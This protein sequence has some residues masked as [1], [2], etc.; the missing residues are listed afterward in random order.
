LL[1][2]VKWQRQIDVTKKTTI[3]RRTLRTL[4]PAVE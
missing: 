4:H 3:H 1:W 2:F